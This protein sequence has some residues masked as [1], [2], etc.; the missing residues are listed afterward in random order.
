MQPV[1][2][3][4]EILRALEETY[5]RTIG[6]EY[7]HIE[8]PE[9]R[10]WLQERMEST[11]NRLALG[12]DEQRRILTKLSDAEILEQF[13][14]RSYGAGTKRFSLEGAESLIPLLDLLIEQASLR[15]VEEIVLGMAHRGRLNVLVNTM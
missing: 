6:V 2:T 13:I 9:Q 7:T 12:E 15:Q 10:E 8:D 4:R 11:H 14:Q 5:C 3:L 1:A